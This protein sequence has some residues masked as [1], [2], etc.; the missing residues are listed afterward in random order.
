M[1]KKAGSDGQIRK[2][3]SEWS[4]DTNTYLEGMRL[5][6]TDTGVVRVSKGTTYALAWVPASGGGGDY[7]P[8]IPKSDVTDLE[9][10]LTAIVAQAARDRH[11]VI[12][13][14]TNTTTDADPGQ[15]TIRF[16]NGTIASVTEIALS[17]A[18]SESIDKGDL[19][20]R[21]AGILQLRTV[22]SAATIEFLITA[23][24][25]TS[26]TRYTVT[27]LKGSLPTNGTAMTY[28]FLPTNAAT[29][30][31]TTALAGKADAVAI[32]QAIISQSGTD[33][34]T[35]VVVVN[36]LGVTVT[37]TRNSA[38]YYTGTY[39]ATLSQTSIG[40]TVGVS[41]SDSSIAL[42]LGYAASNQTACV[43]ETIS[44]VIGGLSE[45]TDYI[46]SS[47]LLTIIAK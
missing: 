37:W 1:A 36:T 38:G 33:D 31:V 42:P 18:D 2:T 32:Y 10:D 21:C 28:K 17:D 35:V 14:S 26:F 24:V 47:S 12:T 11:P 5:M 23:I 29:P 46:L 22:A 13:F 4:A 30:A 43:I 34:P 20:S 41:A 15:A 40:A 7:S 3:T 45:P 9:G 6:D 27:Y 8:P 44:Q 25:H 16:N 19:N 39:S